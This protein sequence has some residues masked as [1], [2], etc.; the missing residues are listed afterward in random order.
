MV[1]ATV[2]YIMMSL[3]KSSRVASSY[4]LIDGETETCV[5]YSDG[6]TIQIRTSP[7]VI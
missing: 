1:L 5:A 7:N 4:H 6:V 2:C 3:Q